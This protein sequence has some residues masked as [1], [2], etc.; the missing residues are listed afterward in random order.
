MDERTF[1]QLTAETKNCLSAG[2]LKD[3]VV[4]L[5]T[6]TDVVGDARLRETV[7]TIREDYERLLDYM[8]TGG[9]DAT[10]EEQHLRLIRRAISALQDTR[11]CYRIRRSSDEYSH[12]MAKH[13][14]EWHAEP[15]EVLNRLSESMEDSVTDEFFEWLWTSAQLK[16]D[17]EKRLADIVDGSPQKIQEFMLSALTLGLLEYFDARK[18]NILLAYADS[19]T[20]GLRAR[21]IVGLSISTQLYGAFFPF[22]P[23]I[24]ERIDNLSINDDLTLVQ[25]DFCLYLETER[26]QQQMQQEIIPNLIKAK[27]Q[28]EKLGFDGDE[29]NLSDP[30]SGLDDDTRN[31]LTDSMREM[32]NLFRDGMDVN[33]TTFVPLKAF[34]F[35]QSPGHWLLPYDRLRPEAIEPE[36]VEKM[37]LCDSDKYSVSLLLNT[38]SQEQRQQIKEQVEEQSEGMMAAFDGDDLAQAYHNVIQCLYRLLKRSPWCSE[39]PVVFSSQMFFTHNS[40]LSERLGR[41]ASFLKK[42]GEILLRYKHYEE[43]KEH[44][45]LLLKLEG[46]T[47]R[48]YQSIALCEEGVGNLQ[49]AVNCYRQANLLEPE[50][51]SLIHRLQSCYARLGQY[52]SQLDCLLELESKNPDDIRILTETGLCL[53]QLSR[54]K[55]AQ[56]R[57]FKMEFNNQRVVPS[58]RA[59]AWCALQT[60]N[61]ELARRYYRR[62]LEESPLSAQW[63]DYLNYGHT[64]WAGGDMTKAIDLYRQYAVKFVTEHPEEKDALAPFDQD[65][66]V[67]MNLGIS[68]NNVYLMHDLIASMI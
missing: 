4:L 18:L 31:K 26:I 15:L 9:E 32:A 55:E 53:M 11:R 5:S 68:R 22:Y 58:Q 45:Q 59:I 50:N 43:A 44:L 16:P 64:E 62:I 6:L 34:P 37:N 3:G 46:G 41:D 21:A 8:K 19:K 42:T 23:E 14:E 12:T 2:R 20:G 51:E 38:V 67:L 17:E 25:H 30:T 29:L 63:E 40:V 33:L 57:F 39:W 65:V 47:A 36:L 56:Q 28:R 13:A 49:S 1:L 35:F 48:T 61:L 52:E 27:R 24:K 66:Q 7:Q 54:W 60:Q 10:R